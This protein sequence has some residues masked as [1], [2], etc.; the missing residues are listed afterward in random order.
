MQPNHH[1]PH[2]RLL[3]IYSKA[4]AKSLFCIQD[5]FLFVGCDDILRPSRRDVTISG[6]PIRQKPDMNS[7]EVPG[8]TCNVQLI[9]KN[10][11]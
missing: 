1:D 7:G 5:T 8:H 3:D 10:L 11:N 9:T 4:P 2:V 6:K